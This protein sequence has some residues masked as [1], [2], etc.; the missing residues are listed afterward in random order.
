MDTTHE[1][2][3]RALAGQL[4]R[5]EP[6]PGP[7]FPCP[8]LPDRWA[9]HV[10]LAP[11]TVSPGAYH[12]LMD[13]NFRRLGPVFYRPACDGCRECRM[14]RLPVAGFRPSRSQR[15]CLAR[16]R[17]VSVE[18]GAP[19]ATEEKRRLYA[20]Y[21]QARHDGEMDGSPEEFE[22]FLYTSRIRTVELSYRAGG[23]LIGAGIADVEP[24]AMSAVYFYFD[25]GEARRAPGVFN[26]LR[27]L[28]ECRRRGLPH[29]YLGF[30]VRGCAKMSYKAGYRPAELLGPDG[31]WTPAGR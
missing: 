9:R 2:R 10:T 19:V 23:R 31:A 11:G 16:N 25:P 22:G 15:R 28:E 4:A 29:L 18:V 24:L 1:R 13:L 14:L 17:D 8:Y 26:V 30:Y 27:L 5:V 21:L 7:A 20:R 12:A 3:T 6:H